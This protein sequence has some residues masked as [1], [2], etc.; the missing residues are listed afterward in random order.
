MDCSKI[1][2]Q[3]TAYVLGEATELERERIDAHLGECPA[4]RRIADQTRETADLLTA[5][6]NSGSD[7][8]VNGRNASMPALS[9]VSF[10]KSRRLMDEDLSDTVTF[11]KKDIPP[12]QFDGRNR[13][14]CWYFY[15]R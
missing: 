14:T 1:Q 9:A 10:R 5:W 6:G 7:K 2:V 3:L 12:V 8:L 13:I 15:L 11:P 4:C